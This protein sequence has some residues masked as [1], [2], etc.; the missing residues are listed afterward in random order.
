[1]AY[2]CPIHLEVLACAVPSSRNSV[3]CAHP[4][5]RAARAWTSVWSLAPPLRPNCAPSALPAPRPSRSPAGGRGGEGLDSKSQKALRFPWV[6]PGLPLRVLC[7]G[8]AGNFQILAQSK[9]GGD[10]WGQTPHPK[11]HP[12]PPSPRSGHPEKMACPLHR[13]TRRDKWLGLVVVVVGFSAHFQDGKLRHGAIRRP[14]L[15]PPH[16]P[17]AGAGRVG[18]SNPGPSDPRACE[19]MASCCLLWVWRVRPVG[20]KSP[21]L[22]GPASLCPPSPFP[23]P[24]SLPRRLAGV[25]RQIFQNLSP[26]TPAG[27]QPGS[28]VWVLNSGAWTCRTAESG[29][30]RGGAG[31]MQNLELG[32]G[33]GGQ[34][35]RMGGEGTTRIE[36]P[37]FGG[38]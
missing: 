36:G 10:C 11:L 37:E 16:P 24:P 20:G 14:V 15:G 3:P 2:G 21:C 12:A 34:G 31:S 22:G 25:W 8:G 17:P 30:W 23:I 28:R 13:L 29:I 1:M 19:L 27:S 5:P 9:P 4:P 7:L 32:G 18:G 38:P 35:F 26:T 33:V 6:G